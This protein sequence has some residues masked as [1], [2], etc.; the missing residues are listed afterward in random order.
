[1]V[2]YE[3]AYVL[4]DSQL[5]PESELEPDRRAARCITTPLLRV[6]TQ[7]ATHVGYRYHRVWQ[8]AEQYFAVEHICVGGG[9]D[10]QFGTA[11]HAEPVTVQ[12]ARGL[13]DGTLAA[14]DRLVDYLRRRTL[15]AISIDNPKYSGLQ[16]ARDRWDI[17]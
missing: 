11:S 1:M 6:Q 9:S 16:Q 12:V 10:P 7:A 15:L 17:A 8:E 13:R 3:P 4:S 5:E 14:D 2:L